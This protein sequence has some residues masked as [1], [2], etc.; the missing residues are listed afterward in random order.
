MLAKLSFLPFYFLLF[1]V[2]GTA[3]CQTGRTTKW[4][5][6]KSSSLRVEG[7]SNINSFTCSIKEYADRDTLICYNDPSRSISFSGEMHMNIQSFDCESS[8][9]TRDMRKTLKAD[10]YPKMTI[11][12]ISL[13]NM[14]QLQKKTELIKGWVEVELAGVVKRFELSY[15]FLQSGSGYLQMNGGRSF[16]FSDFNLLPPRKFAGLIRIKN[17]FEV[18]FQLVLRTI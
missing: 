6:E 14:P 15:S 13:Q 10:E 11:R 7:R 18:N 2:N 5:I 9:I 8:M 17:D 4:V 1:V 3:V 16:Q 12:F